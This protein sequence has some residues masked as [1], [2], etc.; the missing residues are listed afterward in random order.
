M[1][2]A[3][4]LSYTIEAYNVSHA[5]ENKIHDDSVAQKLGFS[6]G[7]VPGVEVFA[8]ASHLPLE[9][10]GRAFLERGELAAKFGKPVYDGRLA[11]ASAVEM[12][13]GGLELRVESEGVE[14]ATGTARLSATALPA[15][16]ISDCAYRTP[17]AV[18]GDRPPADEASLAVGNLL[19]TVPA[20]LDRQKHETYLSDVR[21]KNDIYAREGIAH[22][23]ILLRL[24]NSALREN[25]VMP[26]WI[27][28]GSAMRNISLA[29][30]GEALSARTRVTAN[31]DRK[32]HR[33]VDLDCL[34]LA[35]DRHVAHVSHTAIYKLRHL[36]G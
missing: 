10:W 24:C 6:G 1:T 27:H 9:R 11:T 15:P 34:L 28:V 5:S 31:Y 23:G 8:Y 32:G 25:V 22:P 26:P 4:R 2:D 16:A 35:G 3:S 33:L 14:C 18:L 21:E 13:D 20:V 29:H 19:S 30:V 17:P 36:G 12:P 7:L